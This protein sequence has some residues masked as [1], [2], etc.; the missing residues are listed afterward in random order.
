MIGFTLLS[1]VGFAINI[2]LLVMMYRMYRMVEFHVPEE[3]R[4]EVKALRIGKELFY[5]LPLFMVMTTPAES[6]VTPTKPRVAVSN[7]QDN[8][9]VSRCTVNWNDRHVLGNDFRDQITT[10]LSKTGNYSIYERKNLKTMH[11][12]EHDLINAEA[13]NK[14]TKNK[15]KAAQYSITGAITAFELCDTGGGLS[16]DL[17]S[18][19]G[20][21]GLGVGAD[22]SKARVVLNM[23][24]INVESGEVM[25]SWEAEGTASA[26]GFKASAS[27]FSGMRVGSNAFKNTPLGKAAQEAIKN[28]VEEVVK[29]I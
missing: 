18:L 12:E 17:G 6:A 1:L 25:K 26:V 24:I 16:V 10:E 9:S 11:G 8:G 19:V 29:T 15:F 23:R 14:P 7:F 28:A 13:A 21:S 20:L 27:T 2:M 5:L 3:K 22:A 4:R